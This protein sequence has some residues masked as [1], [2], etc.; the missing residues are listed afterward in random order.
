MSLGE[1]TTNNNN[2]IILLRHMPD[3]DDDDDDDDE[4]SPHLI[5][6]RRTPMRTKAK[7]EMG[8]T[9]RPGLGGWASLGRSLRCTCPACPASK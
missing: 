6:R 4:A 7:C 2:P 1:G 3:D 9:R 5:T 8:R